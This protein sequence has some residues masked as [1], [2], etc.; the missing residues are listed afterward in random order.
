[1]HITN[2]QHLIN[3]NNYQFKTEG[4]CAQVI[5]FGIDDNNNLHNVEFFGGCNGNLKAIGRLVEGKNAEEIASILA[6]NT[7][8]NKSTSCADQLAYAVRAAL[9][10]KAEGNCNCENKNCDNEGNSCCHCH[11]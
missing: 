8:G 2:I 9:K 7:C 10:K 6:G 3:M 1:M 5:R 11:D 4:V